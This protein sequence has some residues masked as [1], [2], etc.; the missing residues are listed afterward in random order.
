MTASATKIINV[1]HQLQKERRRLFISR[2]LSNRLIIISAI[3]FILLLVV[4]LLAPLIAPY[5]P[6]TMRVQDRLQAPSMVHFFGTDNF[7]RDVFSRTIYGTRISMFVGFTVTIISA[8]IGTAV[9]LYASY[10]KVLDHILMRIC[11][12]LMS[13]PAILLAIIIVAVFGPSTR[14]VI[15]AL[16]IVFVPSFARIVRS[17]ALRIKER[18]YIEAERAMGASSARIIWLHIMPNALSPLLVQTTYIF[19]ITIITEA[20]LSYLGAGV[21]APNPSLGNILY[22]GKIIILNGWWMTVFPGLMVIV[23]VL[24]VNLF[25]DGIR[26]LLDPHSN[27]SK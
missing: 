24:S 3:T 5:S 16:V 10:Y 7:G 14:N 11:D 6:L 20:M 2:V 4:S 23:I 9:G 25:G 19:A 21:P 1:K 27:N 8:A 17:A 26:D 12:G 22:D 15:V 18:T 13:F